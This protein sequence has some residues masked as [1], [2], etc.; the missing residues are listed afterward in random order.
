MFSL[1]YIFIAFKQCSPFIQHLFSWS[2]YF[3]ISC[4]TLLECVQKCQ[5]SSLCDLSVTAD[6]LDSCLRPEA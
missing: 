3:S 4:P 2:E 5:H 6:R 1:Y